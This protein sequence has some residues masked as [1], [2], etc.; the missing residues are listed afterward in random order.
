MRLAHF[1]DIHVTQPPADGSFRAFLGKR[2]AATLH[3]YV[4]GRRHRFAEVDRRIESLLADVDQMRVQH[5]L[6]TG[7]ITMMSLPTEFSRFAELFGERLDR[8]QRWT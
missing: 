2:L 7:D 6:C 5:A 1:S 4:G 3:Y 8:P